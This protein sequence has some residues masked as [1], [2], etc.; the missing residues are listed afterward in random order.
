M[1]FRKDRH[2]NM[3]MSKEPENAF[4]KLTCKW[5]MNMTIYKFTGKHTNE[6]LGI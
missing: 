6:N 5:L 3:K 4:Y 1:V 2:F